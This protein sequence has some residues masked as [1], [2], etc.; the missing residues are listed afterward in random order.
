MTDRTI[1]IQ[2]Y[3]LRTALVHQAAF[4]LVAAMRAIFIVLVGM[5]WNTRWRGLADLFKRMSNFVIDSV[6]EIDLIIRRVT[7]DDSVWV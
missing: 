5:V 7:I 3:R 1:A 4:V 6:N 2:M